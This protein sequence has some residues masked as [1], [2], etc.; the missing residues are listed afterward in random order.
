ME[1]KKV[2][3]IGGGAMGGGIAYVLSSVGIETLVKDIEQKFVDKAIEGCKKIYD[4]RV[5]KGK[6]AQEV[7]DGGMALIKGTLT[8]DGFEDVDLIIE[9]VPEVMDIKKKVFADLEGACPEH[10]IFATNTSSLSIEEI[11]KATKRPDKVVGLHFFNPANVMKLV[12]VIY[13]PGTDNKVVETMMDFSTKIKKIPIEVGNCAGFAVN[14]TL[15]PYMGEAMAALLDTPGLTTQEI[16]KAAVEFGMPMGPFILTDLVGLDVGTHAA[17]T[18]EE[19][20]GERCRVMPLMKRMVDAG[21]LGQKSQ[22]GFYDYT[23]EGAPNSDEF[24]KILEEERKNVTPT[25]AKF[26]IS[27]L[28]LIQ[29]REAL[30]LVDEG[31]ASPYDVDTGMVYGTGFPYKTA[32]GPL[33]YAELIMG[34]DEVKKKFD[35]YA[36]SVDK[37]RFA[38][39]KIL[40]DLAS[41]KRR[42]LKRCHYKVDDNGVALMYVD[43]PPM[44]ALAKQTVEDI[45]EAFNA[46]FKDDKV[47][48]IILTGAGTVFVAGADIKEIQFIDDPKLGEEMTRMGQK[49]LDKIEQASKPV[50]AAINGYCLGGG[51]EI[52]SACHIRYASSKAQI[53]VPEI[54]LGII[55]GFGGTQRVPR[56][57]GLARGIELVTTGRF[58]SAQEAYEYG[59]VTKVSAPAD[60]IKDAK[61]LATQMAGKSRLAITAAMTAVVKGYMTTLEEG[62]KIESKEF[63]KL[64]PTEDKKEGIA[65][66]IEK[67]APN[68]KDK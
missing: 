43:N 35:E 4:G 14:R 29:I 8:F 51:L 7:A 36:K 41:G 19:A 2:G 58:L 30:M 54:N 26:D 60:L 28:I 62:L 5:K 12:E 3:V 49:V 48:A 68:F 24:L 66:F 17:G 18:L 44:N 32:W 33:H 13:Y 53:G 31:F 23:K 34:W 27:R 11:S 55:P 52:A 1:I 39:P 67:R 21:L 40:D 20:Y 57:V 47:R 59:L 65:A 56:I 37:V 42:L 46:A 6:M 38:A 22:K 9:A 61:A 63:G 10:T 25:K 16:D 45:E 50:I 15:I 64:V